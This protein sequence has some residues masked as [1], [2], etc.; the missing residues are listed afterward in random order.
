MARRQD[1]VFLA[2]YD[3]ITALDQQRE[4][5]VKDYARLIWSYWRM[6]NEWMEYKK[7]RRLIISFQNVYRGRRTQKA[8]RELRSKTQVLQ[9]AGLV[10]I[11]RE[12]VKDL[13]DA[14]LLREEPG[15]LQ[16][17]IPDVDELINTD[18]GGPLA[19]ARDRRQHAPTWR[20]W[21]S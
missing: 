2:S 18:V 10:K 20:S 1:L 5:R 4:E 7:A 12:R 19:H 15:L 13:R 16:E 21:P 8:Y 6:R 17:Y 3:I 11:A 9:H 14:D